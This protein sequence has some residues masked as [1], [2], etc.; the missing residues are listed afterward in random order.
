MLNEAVMNRENAT[1]CKF[2]LDAKTEF[3][4]MCQ[5]TTCFPPYFGRKYY[6]DLITDIFVLREGRGSH[7]YKIVYQEN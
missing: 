7:L 5:L 4:K 1:P 3:K 2:S 6:F